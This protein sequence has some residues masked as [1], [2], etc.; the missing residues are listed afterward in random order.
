VRPDI[1]SV[2]HAHP[3]YA[4][5]FGIAGRNI[6]PVGNRGAI[7]A[8]QVPI[9]DFDRQIDTPERGRMVRDVL[10]DGLAVILKNHG[11]AVCGDSIENATIA[12]FALEET[13]QLH[14]IAAQLGPVE[15]ISTGEVRSVLTG[16]RKEE[17][18]S[19]VWGHYARLD[20][21]EKNGRT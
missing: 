14:W 12:T 21:W 16:A 20:P 8:P 1:I 7:F 9:L 19:H 5:A 18:Y 2:V 3:T 11:V 15:K 6:F 4:T 10:G 13:A 17:F